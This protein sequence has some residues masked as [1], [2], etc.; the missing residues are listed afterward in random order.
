M[1]IESSQLPNKLT[2]AKLV[3]ASPHKRDINPS[4]DGVKDQEKNN[5]G[6]RKNKRLV[7]ISYHN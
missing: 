5:K 3:V 6:G 2:R 4:I 1:S 7:R